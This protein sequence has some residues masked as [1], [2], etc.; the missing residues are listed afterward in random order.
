MGSRPASRR[1]CFGVAK[2]F[3]VSQTD[4][5]PGVDAA[6]LSQPSAPVEGDT[7]AYLLGP[8]ERLAEGL[9]YAVVWSPG[10]PGEAKG[11]CRRRE[12]RIEVLATLAPNYRVAVLVHELCHAATCSPP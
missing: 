12:R 3:D 1:R 5:L 6:P 4:P 2:V 10:L 9:G 7:H 8:L 11:L